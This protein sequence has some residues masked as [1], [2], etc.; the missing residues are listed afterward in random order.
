MGGGGLPSYFSPIDRRAVGAEEPTV[1][2]LL[3][4]GVDETRQLVDA[5]VD[6][7]AA[8][9]ERDPLVDHLGHAR[10]GVALLL[11]LLGASALA[12]RPLRQRAAETLS[13]LRDRDWDRVFTYRLGAWSAAVEMA[14]ERPW[15]GFG[16]GTFG[17]E[18][19]P[20]RLRA[21]I[22][23]RAKL[24]NPLVTASYGEAH[25]DYLQ[26][27]AEAGVVAGV[28][29]LATVVLLFWGLARTAGRR[30]PPAARAEAVFLLV[31]LGAGAVAALT[32]FPLQRPV[33]AVPLLLAAGRAWRI[34]IP[35]GHVGGPK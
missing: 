19:V 18:F 7:A 3:A 14:R 11:L 24:V 5:S 25:C 30:D 16:P 10:G 21:E 28:A 32:W 2:V 8:P 34:S 31:F 26:P 23:L 22:S 12:Y 4:E 9:L 33:S 17:A 29:V 13:A 35:S 1:A 6:L 27:F 20:H 15:T